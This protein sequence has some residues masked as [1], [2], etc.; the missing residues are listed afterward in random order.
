MLANDSSAQQAA[1]QSLAFIQACDRA[2]C[3]HAV[4]AANR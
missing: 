1:A 3:Y 2:D 4:T